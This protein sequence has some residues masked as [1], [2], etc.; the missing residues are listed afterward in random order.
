MEHS[1]AAAF[2]KII[3]ILSSG[4]AAMQ[5][6]LKWLISIM[7]AIDLVWFGLNV[8]MGKHNSLAALL[9]KAMITGV[10]L[11]IMNNFRSLAFQLQDGLT[12]LLAKAASGFNVNAYLANPPQ[13]LDDAHRLI[14]SPINEAA[15][16]AKGLSDTIRVQ[17]VIGFVTILVFF[18]FLIVTVQ[19]I[20]AAVEFHLILLAGSILLPFTLF[21]PTSFL[22]KRVYEAAIAQVLKLAMIALIS[23]V[24]VS[25]IMSALPYKDQ[26]L[27]LQDILSL[28]YLT[29]VSALSALMGV[30]AYSAP[31]VASSLISGAPSLSL[32]NVPG[33]AGV[34]AAFAAVASGAHTRMLNLAESGTKSL[35]KKAKSKIAASLRAAKAARGAKPAAAAAT[36]ATAAPMP[37]RQALGS[38]GAPM[39][40]LPAP[41][42]RFE[43]RAKTAPK[44]KSQGDKK[45]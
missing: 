44:S 11:F 23:A 5:P 15:S 36:A 28:D 32:Q 20:M 29:Q 33:G 1:L 40:A 7:L 10:S 34:I 31:G 30:L 9:A 27:D 41:K 2:Q 42:P 8:A 37:L 39:L 17:L 3:A 13:I 45:P 26:Q 4:Y 22:G 19:L 21:E 12:A 14:L 24:A 25:A 16:Q 35:G 18:C 38:G 6:H 43:E